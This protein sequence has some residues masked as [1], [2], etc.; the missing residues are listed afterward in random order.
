MNQIEMWER[1]REVGRKGE[2]GEKKR[3]NHPWMGEDE[4]NKKIREKDKQTN[5]NTE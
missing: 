3:E 1:E 2:G 5:Q 4:K